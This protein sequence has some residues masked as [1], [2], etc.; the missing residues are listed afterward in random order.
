MVFRNMNELTD[1]YV[2]VIILFS[3]TLS[4]YN[5]FIMKRTINELGSLFLIFASSFVVQSINNICYGFKLNGYIYINYS[6]VKYQKL[7]FIFHC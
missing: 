4:L 1:V 2:F 3:F 7:F 5:F 6:M